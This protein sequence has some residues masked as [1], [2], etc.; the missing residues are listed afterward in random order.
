MNE[1]KGEE[2]ETKLL[3]APYFSREL[4]VYVVWLFGVCVCVGKLSLVGAG[5][6][7]CMYVCDAMRT[8]FRLNSL[9]LCLLLVCFVYCTN[10]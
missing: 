8:L 3:S 2:S 9:L 5:M 7:V 1:R 4:F 10:T 6:Y